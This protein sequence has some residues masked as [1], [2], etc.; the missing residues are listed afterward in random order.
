MSMIQD[1]YTM[2]GMI[3]WPAGYTMAGMI[4]WPAG[5][6]MAGMIITLAMR[7]NISY[8]LWYNYNTQSHVY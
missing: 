3:H 6:T 8:Q 7:A 5:Y 4:H 2:A 1:S